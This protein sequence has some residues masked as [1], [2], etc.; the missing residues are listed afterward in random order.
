MKETACKHCVEGV[1]DGEVC[2]CCDG[3]GF[4]TDYTDNAVCPH[5]GATQEFDEPFGDEDT[6]QYECCECDKPFNVTAH[7]S[8]SYST[9]KA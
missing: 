5:C 8:V 1:D 2:R 9:V 3:T 7:W 6:K 4:D